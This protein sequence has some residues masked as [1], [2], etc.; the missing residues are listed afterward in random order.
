MMDK[1]FIKD[2]MIRGVIGISE[3]ERSQAQDIVVSV[4]M[5]TDITRGSQTD[6]IDHCVNYRT[7]AKSI[8]AHVEKAARYTV[9]ALAQD[10]ADICLKTENV[11]KVKVM[12]EKPRAVRFSRSVGVEITRSKEKS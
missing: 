4:T 6:N 5:Y 1:V 9:E 8:I 11:E 2:L 7:V 10:I 3:R 12:V